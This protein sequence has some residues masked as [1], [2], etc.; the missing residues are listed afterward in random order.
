MDQ[1]NYLRY[2]PPECLWISHGHPRCHLHYIKNAHWPPF[3]GWQWLSLRPKLVL[4]WRKLLKAK[5]KLTCQ[6]QR[7]PVAEMVKCQKSELLPKTTNA[8]NMFGHKQRKLRL[9]KQVATRWKCLGLASASLLGALVHWGVLLPMI[10]TAMAMP[11]WL[12]SSQIGLRY[13]YISLFI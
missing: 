5:L 2:Y 4:E 12:F 8:T 13:F 11:D 6:R 9:E 3:K 10:L 7:Q 1:H